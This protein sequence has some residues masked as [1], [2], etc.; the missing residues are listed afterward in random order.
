LKKTP[1]LPLK[2]KK[3]LASLQPAGVFN[4]NANSYR[5]SLQNFC[6]K[7]KKTPQK[8]NSGIGRACVLGFFVL[9]RALYICNFWLKKKI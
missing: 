5:E 7:K 2:K 3:P 1:A 9:K 4:V 6:G 8:P